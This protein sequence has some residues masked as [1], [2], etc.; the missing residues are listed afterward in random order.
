ML[1]IRCK[2]AENTFK[3]ADKSASIIFNKLITLLNCI[4]SD[5]NLKNKFNYI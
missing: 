1:L 5:C 2:N 4:T 3:H